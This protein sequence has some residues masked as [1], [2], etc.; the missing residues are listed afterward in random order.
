MAGDVI[1]C[2]WC[3][4]STNLADPQ[5]LCGHCGRNPVQPWEQRGMEPPPAMPDMP[6]AAA[7][8]RPHLEPGEI[9]QRLRIARKELGTGA[10]NAAL[11]EKLGISERQLGRWHKTAG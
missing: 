5:P 11:A 9:K 1:E 10:T 4:Q 6:S 7:G 2:G 8:G 3:G